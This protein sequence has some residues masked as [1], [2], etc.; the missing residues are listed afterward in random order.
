MSDEEE[1]VDSKSSKRDR[2]KGAVARTKTK[3]SKKQK[4][5]S[6]TVDDF[7]ATGRSSTSLSLSRPSVS[8]SFSYE[9]DNT[10]A[11]PSNTYQAQPREHVLEVPHASDHVP[12]PQHSPR[13]IVVPKIDVSNSQRYPAAQPVEEATSN[14]T[15]RPSLLGPEFKGRGP[16][17]SSLSK[18][19]GRARGLSVQFTD[20][21]PVVIG[22]GG[23]EAEAPPLEIGRAKA[24]SRSVSP[25][26]AAGVQGTAARLWNKSPLPSLPRP[27]TTS[28]Q[29]PPQNV[30][31][32]PQPRPGQHGQPGQPG[33]KR[34]Q[35]GMVGMA[36]SPVSESR[37]AM[38]REFEMSMGISP[39]STNSSA[40]SQSTAGEPP[41][42]HAPKPVHPPAPYPKVKEVPLLHDLRSQHGTVS[43]R[44]KYAANEGQT[45]REAHQSPTVEATR[46]TEQTRFPSQSTTTSQR[47]EDIHPIHR[48]TLSSDV[49]S[50]RLVQPNQQRQQ[51]PPPP[52]Y[53]TAG[54]NQG[55]QYYPP[56]PK[57]PISHVHQIP[58]TPQQHAPPPPTYPPPRQKIP[59]PPPPLSAPQRAAED[60]YVGWVPD[61]ASEAQPQAHAFPGVDSSG[62]LAAFPGVDEEPGQDT[63][64][65]KSKR[66]W[67][68][69]GS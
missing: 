7:L 67:F 17:V 47:P 12:P 14:G 58:N 66:R 33:L 1:K 45:F 22:E 28:P 43:L 10:S 11:T 32:S 36:P 15:Q 56:P 49:G 35:T 64:S 25:P 63:K 3:L 44:K 31:R 34:V 29:P 27:G 57:Q 60:E 39:V 2:L 46:G 61:S 41:V 55:A 9:Q 52:A 13:R 18:G 68:R 51:P 5:Q 48:K 54:P 23:D 16:S 62:K 8:E 42:L 24:R 69:R 40:P 59:P 53:P 38:D 21:P 30:S 4:E 65:G 37:Q 6:T 26:R 19:P 20:Y 50:V